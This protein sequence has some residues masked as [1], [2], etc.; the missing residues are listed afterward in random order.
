MRGW[1]IILENLICE[2]ALN[3]YSEKYLRIIKEKYRTPKTFIGSLLAKEFVWEQILKEY[4]QRK[5]ERLLQDMQTHKSVE[6]QCKDLTIFAKL[7]KY[8]TRNSALMYYPGIALPIDLTKQD[9]NFFFKHPVEFK[10]LQQRES[11]KQIVALFGPST[12]QESYVDNE[13][14]TLVFKLQALQKAHKNPRILLNF[15]ISGYTLYEQFML[16]TSLIYPLKPE[17]VIAVFFGV[18]IF[19]GRISCEKLLEQHAIFYGGGLLE[20]D[21][22]D[23]TQSILPMKYQ[24]L[25]AGEKPTLNTD[26]AI[27]EALQTRLEQ[28]NAMVKS[29]GGKF[30]PI[31]TPLLACKKE[32]SR[33]EKEN[34]S[35]TLKD[36]KNIAYEDTKREISLIEA[37]KAMPRDFTLYD[38]NAA[39]KESK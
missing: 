29:Y 9:K 26:T 23:L 24:L 35:A 21:Y 30:Y 19:S 6:E 39:I 15:G 16:Y 12:M 3:G 36:F 2:I 28:F 34:Y 8:G 22:R 25:Q 27:L 17:I 32:W 20:K 4:R 31:I 38:G 7:F 5:Q 14:D 11:Q 33:E 37:F 1:G 18:D 10:A 13:S